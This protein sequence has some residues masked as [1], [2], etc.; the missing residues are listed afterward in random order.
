MSYGW[1][2]SSILY[3]GRTVMMS[4]ETIVAIWN[5]NTPPRGFSSLSFFTLSVRN[6]TLD[7]H[8]LKI[9]V[10]LCVLMKKCFFFNDEV[11]TFGK[12]WTLNFQALGIKLLKIWGWAKVGYQHAQINCHLWIHGENCESS[13]H[14]A[15]YLKFRPEKCFRSSGY[16]LMH[17][18]VVIYVNQRA[19]FLL[20]SWSK[21]CWLPNCSPHAL[22]VKKSVNQFILIVNRQVDAYGNS[23]FLVCPVTN[24]HF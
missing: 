9:H 17:I 16:L 11:V 2:S 14:V 6:L 19:I 10:V 23:V 5:R 13:Y 22:H 7:S 21:R 18:F 24:S 12:Y 8:G 1:S 20:K 4:L 3:R 15:R